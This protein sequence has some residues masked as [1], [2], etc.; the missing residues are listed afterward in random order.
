MCSK[1]MDAMDDLVS[2][3]HSGFGELCDSF[4]FRPVPLFAACYLTSYWWRSDQ[5]EIEGSGG[6][7]LFLQQQS[8]S[9]VFAIM[10]THLKSL[11]ISRKSEQHGKKA[12]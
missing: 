8:F 2:L 10:H 6:S 1:Q 11:E 3:D 5:M 4:Q 12:K 9:S 7:N